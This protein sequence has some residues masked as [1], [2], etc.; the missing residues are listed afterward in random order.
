MT[1]PQFTDIIDYSIFDELR[2][3][4]DG[5]PQRA[6]TTEIITE[7]QQQVTLRMQSLMADL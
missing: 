5:D 7:F 6:F 1:E 4:D 3:M 2:E